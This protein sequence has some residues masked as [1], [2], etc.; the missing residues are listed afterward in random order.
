MLRKREYSGTVTKGDRAFS[1]RLE[2]CEHEDKESDEANACCAYV[3]IDQEA[4]TDG[5]QCPSHLREREKK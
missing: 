1:M 2:S 4:K 5:K 3:R